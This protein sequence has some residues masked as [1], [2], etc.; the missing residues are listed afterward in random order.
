MYTRLKEFKDAATNL[1]NQ[2]A[3]HQPVNPLAAQLGLTDPTSAPMLEGDAPALHFYRHLLDQCEKFFDAEI[4]E[5]T[6]EENL[7]YLFGINAY[8]AYTMDKLAAAIIKQTQAILSDT[9]SQELWALLQRDRAKERTT[10]KQQIAYRVQAERVLAP[11]ENLYMI[12]WVSN[13]AT[14]ALHLTDRP[15]R[16]SPKT[17]HVSIHLLSK[18]D[19]TYVD[20]HSE[21]E[22]WQAYIDSFALVSLS[23]RR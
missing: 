22:R 18:T 20:L 4:D 16:Q 5:R 12:S 14:G 11:D 21:A 2:A 15:I 23:G 9:K 6:F 10:V 19:A 1:A 8:K 3:P 13:I 7:R 17:K